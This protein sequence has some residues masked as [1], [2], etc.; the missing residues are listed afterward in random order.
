MLAYS[1][2][3]KELNHVVGKSPVADRRGEAIRDADSQGEMQAFLDDLL[4]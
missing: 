1:G 2:C 4:S 3:D